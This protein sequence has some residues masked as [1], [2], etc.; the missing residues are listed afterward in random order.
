MIAPRGPVDQL[1]SWGAHFES[2]GDATDGVL[3]TKNALAGWVG[4]IGHILKIR[5]QATLIEVA[6][7]RFGVMV[8]GY[9]AW[10]SAGQQIWSAS[11]SM[12]SLGGNHDLGASALNR[13]VILELWVE[14]LDLKQLHI[15]VDGRQLQSITID[16]PLAGPTGVFSEAGAVVQW[17]WIEISGSLGKDVA[18]HLTQ[19]RKFIADA[20]AAAGPAKT[21]SDGKSLGSFQSVGEGR[22]TASGGHLRGK[23]TGSGPRLCS[24]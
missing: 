18:D 3:R 10:V 7:G 14:E 9:H 12:K 21:L 1:E 17:D 4:S 2:K 22:W 19:Y 13:P 16:E 6:E 11:P 20:R 15:V 5:A 24:V 8:G 23:S